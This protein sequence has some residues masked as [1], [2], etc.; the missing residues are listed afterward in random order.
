MVSVPDEFWDKEE[1]STYSP[2]EKARQREA[3]KV[4]LSQSQ[5]K[6]TRRSLEQELKE[7]EENGKVTDAEAETMVSEEQIGDLID[8]L[9][10][11]LSTPEIEALRQASAIEAQDPPVNVNVQVEDQDEVKDSAQHDESPLTMT[12][13]RK[14]HP[15]QRLT[16]DTLGESSEEQVPTVHRSDPGATPSTVNWTRGNSTITSDTKGWDTTIALA[17]SKIDCELTNEVYD[18]ISV[19]PEVYNYLSSLRWD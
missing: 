9:S 15:P 8:F 2:A 5:R 6:R 4:P 7:S 14:V 11:V 16:Y 17:F 1:N 18:L 13:R 3:V 12:L 10:K 19:S